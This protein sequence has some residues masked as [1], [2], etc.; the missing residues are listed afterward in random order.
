MLGA[1]VGDPEGFGVAVAIGEVD[2][3]GDAGA[4]AVGFGVAEG[5]AEGVEVAAA[6]A[7]GG[8]G[9]PA[10]PPEHPARSMTTSGARYRR[11]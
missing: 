2:A 6:V 1:I 5:F 7:I 11:R 4:D 10:P 8:V 3:L 9:T